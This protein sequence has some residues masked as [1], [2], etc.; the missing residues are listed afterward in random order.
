MTSKMVFQAYDNEDAENND[1]N[2]YE[3]INYTRKKLI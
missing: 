3:Y 1:Y 2:L